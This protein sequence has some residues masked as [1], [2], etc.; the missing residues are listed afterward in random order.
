VIREIR[1]TGKPVTVE[2]THYDGDG[3]LQINEIHGYP[4][5]DSSGNI[6]QVIE[7]NLDITDRKHAEEKIKASL[8][9][10]EILLREIHHRT[11]NNMQVI[12]SLLNLQSEYTRDEKYI[13]MLRE[14]RNRID[15]MALV[16][17]KLYRSKDIS[18][19]DFHDYIV[20]LVN[21]LY[22][23]YGLNAG[24]IALKIDIEHITL[25]PDT[26]IPCGL[27]IN[28]L[29]SNS[30]KHAFPGGRTGEIRIIFR[31]TALTRTEIEYNLT[32]GDNGVGMPEGLDI[33]TLK[34]LGLQLVTT[35]VQHQLQGRL[36]FDRTEGTTCRI[37]FKEVQYETRF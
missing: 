6:A 16:H 18:N 23:F 32:V 20:S 30:L 33:S 27:I 34:T 36:E 4:I 25:E 37:S 11:K 14:S 12:S 17:E 1:E 10:K 2:H 28:E 13:A 8:K 5:F 19:I 24:R 26:A 7:Y 35:L 22:D 3:N 21:R 29:V 9:E 15:T 31:R